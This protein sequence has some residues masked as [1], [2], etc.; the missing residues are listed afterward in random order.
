LAQVNI[1]ELKVKTLVPLI[2][3][4]L[5]A[6]TT[7]FADTFTF[8]TTPNAPGTD[9][10]TTSGRYN[11]GTQQFDLDH[12]RAYS[13]QIAGLGVPAGQTIT[14]ASVT[15]RN[16][17]NWDTNSNM[18]FVHLFDSAASYATANGSR[19]ATITGVTSFL[20]TDPAQVPVMSIVDNF[21]PGNIASNPLGVSTG[22]GQ[23]TFL[24]QQSFN[25]VGQN[26]YTATNF[27]WNFTGAQLEALAAYILN[28]GDLAFGFDPDCHFWNNGITFTYTTTPT[29]EPA[30]MAL[31]GSGLA[32]LSYF[33]RR[34]RRTRLA[35][36][37]EA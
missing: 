22:V 11:G 10:N 15:F 35:K 4:F 1:G 29:P 24:F 18:L 6:S 8:S 26:G 36:A 2:I 19:T 34:R 12:H 27:T 20:D 31:L 5:A 32:G 21:L 37:T 28:G 14:S 7:A 3:L 25:M 33:Q 16:I 30:A 9:T 13:W 23:N 17:A